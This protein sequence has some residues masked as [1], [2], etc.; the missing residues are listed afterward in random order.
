MKDKIILL[1]HGS[2]ASLMHALIENVLLP[3]FD[4]PILKELADA[5]TLDLKGKI[6]FTT[7]SFVVSPLFFPGADIGKLAVCGTVND[8]VM[9]GAAP[10]YLS[11]GLII[12]EGLEMSV[13][14]KI[15]DSIA[16]SA[17]LAKVKIVTG[18]FKVVEKGA[19]DK[20]F[21]NTSGV[22]R[23]ISKKPLSIKSIQTGDK[24]IITGEIAQHGL[25]VLAKRKNLDLKLDIKSDCQELGGLLLSIIEKYD[26]VRFMRDP[27]RGGL[28]TTLNEI[29]RASKKGIIINERDIPVSSRVSTACE[30]LGI[31]P[32][33]VANEGKAVIVVKSK[34]ANKVLA[35]LKKHP[36]G[37]KAAIIGEVSDDF[38]SKVILNTS[39][40]TQRLVDMLS[41]EQ[42]P[43]IC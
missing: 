27:T 33:Y 3:R 34:D 2:G 9:A 1:S 40:G 32:L 10:E 4:N 30:L 37:K 13:L 6:A 16:L 38:K 22:G 41:G 11:L 26:A 28:A 20:I 25:A 21:I 31:D 7:D 42:L 29:T 17:R 43:R 14:E 39:I 36:F 8:L 35:M 24:V 18:D 12:E 19:C 23:I 5:A 15:C